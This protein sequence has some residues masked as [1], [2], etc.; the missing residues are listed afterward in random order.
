MSFISHWLSSKKIRYL[1]VVLFFSAA[2]F[3][4]MAFKGG[5]ESDFDTTRVT[6]HGEP[7]LRVSTDSV[8]ARIALSDWTLSDSLKSVAAL[9]PLSVEG[10]QEISL[11][12]HQILR[13]ELIKRIVF[14]SRATLVERRALKSRVSDV[15]DKMALLNR[16]DQ[17]HGI[18]H[19]SALVRI[20]EMKPEFL[21]IQKIWSKDH[22]FATQV[23]QLL[24]QYNFLNCEHFPEL[25]EQWNLGPFI[26]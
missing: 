7:I 5:S 1:V 15:L 9:A 3:V 21:E 18:S 11:S 2:C 24:A 6:P 19:T 14:L 22:R 10:H 26:Q 4:L 16:V 8:T 12:Y 13:E 20:H 25:I 17:T 23:D